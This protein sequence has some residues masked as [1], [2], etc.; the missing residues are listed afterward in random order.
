VTLVAAMMHGPN[1]RR[2]RTLHE[3]LGIDMRTLKRWRQWWLETFVQQPFWKEKKAEFMP[4]LEETVMPYC[5][6]KSFHATEPEGL[7]RLMKFLAPIT[8][9]S[10]KEGM[11][12]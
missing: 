2:M 1:A 12:M 4:R 8:T 6:A 5:L 9:G 10:V 7:V 11:A 3:Q